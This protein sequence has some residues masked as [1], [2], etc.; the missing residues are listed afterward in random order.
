M[1]HVWMISFCHF[2]LGDCVC[3][4]V[5]GLK[6]GQ[7]LLYLQRKGNQSWANKNILKLCTRQERTKGDEGHLTVMSE[8]LSHAEETVSVLALTEG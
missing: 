8:T 6:I 5:F 7:V 4:G 2:C 1:S 3:R